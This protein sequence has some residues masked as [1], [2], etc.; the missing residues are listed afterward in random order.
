ML[1]LIDGDVLVYEIG[2]CGEYDEVGEETN[3]K[4]HIIREWDFV[5]QLLVQRIE[6]I[7]QDVGAT[8][9]P[10]I[11][12]TA[13]KDRIRRYNKFLKLKGLEPR[14]FIVPIRET[15]ATQKPYKGTRKQTKPWHFDNIFEYLIGN[16]ECN[17]SSNGLEADDEMSIFQW[18]CREKQDTI[19][20][21]RDKDLR[22]TPGW[23]FG[24]ECGKQA[25]Y[26]PE[27]IDAKGGLKLK[28]NKNKEGKVIGY[29]VKGTGL[30]FFFY[31]MLVGDTVDNI[32]G[33]PKVG[34]VKAH[35]LLSGCS[36]K[37]EHEQAVIDAYKNVYGEGF[38][39]FLEE[40]SKLLWMVRELDEDGRPKHYDW[41]Y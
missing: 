40:Q 34:P 4:T 24:W 10:T 38:Q 5:E 28:E 13:S 18:G 41:K 37:R 3:E 36:T 16:Y 21:S 35:Q 14:E 25:S 1:P 12:L 31:Q 19:I 39:P 2:W 15:I 17:I 11:F 29:D 20:C 27:L 33:C 23:Q 6:G 26:G 9:A 8:E 7:C 30:K 22:I 32:P